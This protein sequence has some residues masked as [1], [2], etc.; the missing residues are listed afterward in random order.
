MG[1]VIMMADELSAYTLADR[2]T[3]LAMKDKTTLRILSQGDAVLFNPYGIITVNPAKWPQANYAGAK[4]L[5]D[6]ITGP[7]GQ[8]L[9]A[10]YK[11]GGEQCFYLYKK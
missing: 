2:A 7:E 11:I 10:S 5:M 4:A 9:I 6:W 1:P 3:W 8:A